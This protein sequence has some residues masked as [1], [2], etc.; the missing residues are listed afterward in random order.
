[1]CGIG[2][3]ACKLPIWEVEAAYFRLSQLYCGEF[4][5]L[6]DSA[7]RACTKEML[8]KRNIIFNYG[9]PTLEVNTA[10]YD[11]SEIYE[12]LAPEGIL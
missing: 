8:L 1:M 6:T 3:E 4:D 12:A 11:A 9:P 5:N 7:I 2:K 10:M